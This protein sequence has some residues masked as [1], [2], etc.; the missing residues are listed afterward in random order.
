VEGQL[1]ASAAL[2]PGERA[3][4]AHYIRKLDE[5]QN[6][7]GCFGVEKISCAKGVPGVINQPTDS[8]WGLGWRSG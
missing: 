3:P 7:S 1:H 6:Q 8:Q 2:T 5:P 4:G